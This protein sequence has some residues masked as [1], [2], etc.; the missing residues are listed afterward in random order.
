MDPCLFYIF[1]KT[2]LNQECTV[3]LLDFDRQGND[4]VNYHN[5]DADDYYLLNTDVVLSEITDA[6]ITKLKI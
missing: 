5:C 3:E 6:E 2:V 1:F 4:F